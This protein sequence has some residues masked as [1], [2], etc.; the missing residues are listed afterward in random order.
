MRAWDK[1][2]LRKLGVHTSR[3]VREEC[4]QLTLFPPGREEKL[5]RLELALDQI[6]A[7]YGSQAVTRGC[8]LNERPEKPP[9]LSIGRPPDRPS[10]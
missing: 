1:T 3:V 4:S 9:S 10:F 2:P 6:R 8:F 5:R 7:A